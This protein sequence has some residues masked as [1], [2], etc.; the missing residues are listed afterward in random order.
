MV[1]RIEF[2]IF[3]TFQRECFAFK[4]DYEIGAMW[5]SAPQTEVGVS[6]EQCWS[7]Q[8]PLQKEVIFQNSVFYR[9]FWKLKLL[10]RWEEP[11]KYE[12]WYEVGRKGAER[13]SPS[14]EKSSWRRKQSLGLSHQQ[15]VGKVM[16]TVSG[17][18]LLNHNKVR[19]ISKQ[20]P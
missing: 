14:L 8:I 18:S 3:M 20:E 7:I 10:E 11:E 16:E 2:W 13:T 4:V 1:N 9:H 15:Q 17:L 12:R 6:T 19:E 5:E